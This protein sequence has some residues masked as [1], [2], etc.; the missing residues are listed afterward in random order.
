MKE[1]QWDIWGFLPVTSNA[2]FIPVT[3]YRCLVFFCK[4]VIVERILH[5]LF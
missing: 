3:E 4:F 2:D 1:Q 5:E